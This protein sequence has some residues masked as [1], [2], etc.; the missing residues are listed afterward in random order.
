MH[1][2]HLRKNLVLSP[3][4]SGCLSSRAASTCNEIAGFTTEQVVVQQQKLDSR[5]LIREGKPSC[6]Q[7]LASH[8]TANP[9]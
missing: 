5:V 3:G 2:L 4:F 9:G 6:D 1:S 7:S 8:P